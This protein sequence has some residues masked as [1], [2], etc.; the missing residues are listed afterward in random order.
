MSVNEYRNEAIRNSF[1][2]GL[3]NSNV[4]K[5]LLESYTSTLQTTFDTARTSVLAQK[6]S[7][8][9]ASND[10]QATSYAAAVTSEAEL[11]NSSKVQVVSAI[12]TASSNK[13]KNCC[14][15]GYTYHSRN[16]CAAK[17]SV[18]FECNEI[19]HF[20]LAY[21]SKKKV[22]LSSFFQAAKSSDCSKSLAKS[23]IKIKINGFSANALID[24]G[25]TDSFIYPNQLELPG[26][27][28]FSGNKTV[29]SPHLQSKPK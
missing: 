9:Y 6:N 26:L 18:C 12:A 2:S 20:S 1:I 19:G 5:R 24:S 17:N 22:A 25:S 15:C 8:F 10:M 27:K 23:C 14:V 16:I 29:C 13:N 3:F 7:E 11:V 4:R 28:M 21:R